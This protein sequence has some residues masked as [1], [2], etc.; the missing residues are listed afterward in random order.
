MKE[1]INII[2]QAKLARGK[3]KIAKIKKPNSLN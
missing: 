1:M 3:R 2:L